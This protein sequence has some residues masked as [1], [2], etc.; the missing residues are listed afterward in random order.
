MEPRRFLR[1]SE[2][3]IVQHG[4]QMPPLN[5]PSALV[6]TFCRHCAT[7][8]WNVSF[9]R[10]TSCNLGAGSLTIMNM[11]RFGLI[12]QRGGNCS[13]IS[14]ALIPRAQMSTCAGK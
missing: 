11:T 5:A 6:P 14:T 2:V 8:S 12:F 7:K 13:A 4:A 3:M 10:S 9:H 1:V